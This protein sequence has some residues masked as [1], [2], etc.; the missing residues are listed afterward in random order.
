MNKMYIEYGWY[1]F[2]ISKFIRL[3]GIKDFLKLF[4]FLLLGIRV[5]IKI[6]WLFKFFKIIIN[7]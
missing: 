7:S 5:K 1:D 4:L 6:G 2:F 3:L